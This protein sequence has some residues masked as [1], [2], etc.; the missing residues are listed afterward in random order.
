MAHS[1]STLSE[2]G[3][4]YGF[5]K[6][7]KALGVTGVRRQRDRLSTWVRRVPA[8]PRRAGRALLRP[9]RH[10]PVRGGR[11][12]ARARP[13]WF[14]PRRVDDAA[15]GVER[16]RGRPRVA[17]DR[18]QGRLRRARRAARQPGGRRA[19]RELREPGLAAGPDE[20]CETRLLGSGGGHQPGLPAVRSDLVLEQEPEEHVDAAGS[21]CAIVT[22]WVRYA[23]CFAYETPKNLSGGFVW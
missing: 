21:P 11:R 14:V 22:A 2:L 19:A 12:D 8:L 13:G 6:V 23:A 17:G 7:R 16:G 4:G 18:W 3:D 10:G 1:F 5:R 15:E 9:L 20:R